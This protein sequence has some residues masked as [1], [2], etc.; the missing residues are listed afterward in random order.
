MTSG[1]VRGRLFHRKAPQKDIL[2]LNMSMLGPGKAGKER[3][4]EG[5][6]GR[7]N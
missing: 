7:E 6:R 5:E 3:E 2:A 1:S 4:R